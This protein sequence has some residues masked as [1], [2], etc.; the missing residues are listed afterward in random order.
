MFQHAPKKLIP[1][2][3]CAKNP[4]LPVYSIKAIQSKEN[5]II[6]KPSVSI[7]KPGVPVCLSDHHKTYLKHRQEDKL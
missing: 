1:T 7:K 4:L 5:C 2:T 3:V 6:A